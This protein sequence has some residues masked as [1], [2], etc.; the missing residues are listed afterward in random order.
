MESINNQQEVKS[1]QRKSAIDIIAGIISTVF[2]PLL[3]PTYAILIALNFS[4]I[5]NLSQASTRLLVTLTTL[6]TTCM[7]PACV[8]ALLYKLGKISD[9]GVNNQKDRLIPYCVTILCYIAC[10]IYLKNVNAPI[11]IPMFMIGAGIAV[12]TSAI[13]NF[14]WK[15]SA[16]AAGIGGLTALIFTIWIKGYNFIDFM[17]I[18]A[19]AIIMTGLVGSARI[20]LH[21]HTLGQVFAG[22]LNGF[23]W[24]FI[25]TI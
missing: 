20:I 25:M 13:I 2:S 24:V 23:F 1:L 19:I 18:A 7:L 16:H 5:V 9:P 22:A 17:P 14:K 4:F 8:I 21:R 15:I 11:W 6:A 3:I 12:I 10:A